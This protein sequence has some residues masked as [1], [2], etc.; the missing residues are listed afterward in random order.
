MMGRHSILASAGLS[1]VGLLALSGCGGG[2]QSG[3]AIPPVSIVTPSPTPTPTPTPTPSPSPTPTLVF[4]EEFNTGT[5]DRAVWN[6]EGPA[7]WVNNE[8]QAYVDEP[9][10]I[11]F[12]TPAG[13]DGGALILKPVYRPGYVT[14]T[15]RVADFVSGRINTSGNVEMTY[16]RAAARIRMPAATGVWPAFW[17]LG[18][19]QWPDAGEIDIME[20]VGDPSW[21]AAAIHG[22]GYSGETPFVKR[23]NFPAGTPAGPDVTGWHEYAVERTE[24][25]VVFFI[26]DREFYRVTRTDV[27]QYGAWRF[28]RPQYVILNFA[29]GGVYPQKVNGIT[30]PYYGMPQSTADRVA[31]GEIQMEVDWVRIWSK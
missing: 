21:T 14:P 22:P 4:A 7:F 8:L 6:V 9:E 11:S 29:L 17:M 13:A 19:G 27:A 16:G 12:G 24:D 18:Y 30:A 23:Q 1:M 2:S 10:V 28:D 3:S 26:D 5:L 20:Y 31:N 25:A 15:G